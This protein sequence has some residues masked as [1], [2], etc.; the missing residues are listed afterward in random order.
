MERFQA[1]HSNATGLFATPPEDL[2]P[3]ILK[4]ARVRP[5]LLD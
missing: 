2:D 5:K 4:L 1:F 3:L